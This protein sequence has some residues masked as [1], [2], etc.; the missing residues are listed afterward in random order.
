MNF[1]SFSNLLLLTSLMAVL[2]AALLAPGPVQARRDGPL[3]TQPIN[4]VV[5]HATGGPSCDA[6]TGRPIWVGAGTLVANLRFIEAHPKLGIH[7]MIDRDGSLRSSVPEH[8][9]AHH[10][11][12]FSGRSIAIEL[13][14][15][16][17]GVDPFPA[18]QLDA[19]VGLLRDIRQRRGMAKDGVVR[20]SDLDTDVMPCD[21]SRRRKVDPGHA[22]PFQ[23]VLDRVFAA[24]R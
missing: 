14:N 17:D 9:I 21:H 3:R 11:F 12:R 10:V 24:P 23:P 22:F 20:H 2:I 19:L 5:I 16:G 6:K 7:Y 8:Q 15:D 18:P 1:L 13:I 4:M